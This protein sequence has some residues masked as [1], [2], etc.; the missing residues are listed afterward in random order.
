MKVRCRP[1]F[2][3][4][5]DTARTMLFDLE[6]DPAQQTPIDDPNPQRMMIDHLVRLMRQCHAP[7]EQLQRLG[8]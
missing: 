1:W 8:L 2:N 4:K 5:A 3:A 7:H 6:K